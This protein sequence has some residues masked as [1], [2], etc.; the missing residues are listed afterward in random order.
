MGD[1]VFGLKR[2][3]SAAPAAVLLLASC[4][5]GTD[6]SHV[7]VGAVTAGVGAVATALLGST[8]LQDMSVLSAL[9]P[10]YPT[11]PAGISALRLRLP[12][13]AL[14]ALPMTKPTSS[15]RAAREAAIRVFGAPSA[16]G[17]FPAAVLG[18]TIAWDTLSST[19]KIDST[20]SGAPANGIRILIYTSDALSGQPMLPLTLTGYLELTDKSSAQTATLGT[21]LALGSTAVAQYDIAFATGI[22][23]GD[24]AV[25]VTSTGFINDGAGKPVTFAFGDTSSVSAVGLGG[26]VTGSDGTSVQTYVTLQNFQIGI[27]VTAQ[28]G[29]NVIALSAMEGDISAAISGTV[30]FNGTSVATMGG[31]LSAPTFTG[32]GGRVL[33]GTET[34]GLAEIFAGG[35][36]IVSELSNLVLAP[37]L[38]VF[39]G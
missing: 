13:R 20:L 25:W 23:R 4:S 28:K 8:S 36:L 21:L 10:H 27:A 38:V 30:T 16:A 32:A 35:V 11:G 1:L 18:R 33:T 3:R 6:P 15:V 17:L 29:A 34:S 14:A 7:D 26:I 9:F 5:Y 31:T 2:L 22:V 24:S 37:A 39:G 12:E 19:Y